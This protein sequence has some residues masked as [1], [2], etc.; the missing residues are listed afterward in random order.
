M[1]LRSTLLAA[2]LA[3][4]ALLAACTG[5]DDDAMMA[6]DRPATTSEATATATATAAA[7]ATAEATP[8]ATAT[9]SPSAEAAREAQ[10]EFVARRLQTDF[11]SLDVTK[12]TC[13]PRRHH[14]PAAARRDPLDR[15][16]AVRHRR[17]RERVAGAAGAGDLV[18]ARG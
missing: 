18:R 16:A 12:A 17:G 3:A 8:T 6:D 7:E 4:A 2:G 14:R 10:R 5:D 15:R 11:P 13:R 9:P 1:Y